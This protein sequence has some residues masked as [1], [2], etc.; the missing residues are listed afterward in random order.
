MVQANPQPDGDGITRHVPYGVWR[1][2]KPADAG[3][4]ADLVHYDIPQDCYDNF[5]RLPV[6]NNPTKSIVEVFVNQVRERPNHRFLGTRKPQ[7]D[8]TFGAYEWQT[9]Q[10]VFEKY[11]EIAKGCKDL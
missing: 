4:S 7:A 10:E 6:L 11:E 1:T 9:Y 8:G 2:D 3:Y 5:D